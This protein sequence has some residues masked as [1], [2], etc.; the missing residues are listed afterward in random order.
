MFI[1][2]RL[3]IRLGLRVHNFFDR[4]VVC[5]FII[6][7]LILSTVDGFCSYDFS[8]AE[9]FSLK[10]V[11]IRFQPVISGVFD[12]FVAGT[13]ND[14]SLDSHRM[15]DLDD[16]GSYEITLLLAPGRY[17]YRFIVDG[18]WLDDPNA[19]AYE[20]STE[21]GRNAVLVVDDRFGDVI[22]RKGDGRILVENVPLEF[23]YNMINPLDDGRIEFSTRMNTGDV[24]SVHLYYSWHG[25][26]KRAT[27]HYDGKDMVYDYYRCVIDQ[28]E[29]GSI[30]FYFTYQDG[31]TVVYGTPKGI[32]NEKPETDSMFEYHPSLLPVFSTPD[33]AKNGV[34]YQIF[35][36]RFWNGD[37][38][39]DQKFDE[40]YYD[41]KKSL[42]PSGKTNAEYFHFVDAWNDI[43]GLSVSPFR[44]DGRPDYYSFYG[45]DIAGVMEKLPY[46][47]ELGITIIYFNPL[48]EGK[49]NHKYD[50]VDYLRIDPHFADE[51]TFK[52]F[53]QKAHEYG[54]RII[55]DMAFNHTGDWHFAF[56]DTREKGPESE[57]WNW[58][59]WHEWPLPSEGP[60]T[61]CH[62]YECWWNFPLHPNL[63]FDL[64]RANPDENTVISI[65]QT[66]PN[67]DVINYVL[68]VPRYWLGVLDI[69]GFRLDVPNEVPFWMWKEFR[70]VVDEVKPEAFL[71]GELWGDATAYLGPDYF[72]ST[73]NYK[74]FREPVFRFFALDQITAEQ[75]DREL[76]PGRKLYPWQATLTMMNLVGSHDTERFINLVQG[77]I[78]R[79]MLAAIFQMTYVGIPHIY[80]GDEV[81]LAG[82]SDPDNRRPFPWDWET[83]DDSRRLHSHYRSLIEIRHRYT[84]LRTGAFETVVADG[85]VY[86][87]LRQDEDNRIM[88]VIN[89]QDVT[90][91]I[92]INLE[93]FAFGRRSVFRDA[94]TDSRYRM[95][96][97]NLNLG[98]HPMS[99]MILVQ[100]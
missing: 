66:D 85:R 69:D 17:L 83:D 71:I 89:N 33:W 37:R 40:A 42:P 28:P 8:A 4:A 18:S 56:V 59:E 65:Q 96:G 98:L 30:R 81:A 75:F 55:V 90:R 11:V 23:G 57:Y 64:S 62:Y 54:I 49:S 87:F 1:L 99:G 26:T 52:R 51:V 43:D 78:D 97:F 46:L 70:R 38:T 44:T 76:A 79:A 7:V 63:N 32:V 22:N 34:F 61:P 67:L 100:E 82:G 72:H 58:F 35:P 45:G 20:S 84:A 50:A 53:V 95:K 92:A 68:D 60:P 29:H 80:Y 19:S 2:N 94:L 5:C 77:E 12:V 41:G 13:F 15:L 73:M 21:G 9:K 39:N 10:S 16:D 24:E 93:A 74:Y 86:G 3:C 91:E 36:E 14:W 31:D 27:L 88:V 48:N 25:E 6:H 47:N